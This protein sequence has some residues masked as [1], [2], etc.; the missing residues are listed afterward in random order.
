MNP[1]AERASSAFNQSCHAIAGVNSVS[2]S[3]RDCFNALI[4]IFS[5]RSAFSVLRSLRSV[6]T[7]WILRTP[8]SMAF[9]KSHSKRSVLLVG[10]MTSVRG[11]FGA[12]WVSTNSVE[13]TQRRLSASVRTPS[14]RW[15]WPST[16]PMRSPSAARNTRTKCLDSSGSKVW[17]AST[18]GA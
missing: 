3:C 15:P 4:K 8:Y 5:Q 17:M 6:Q 13:T 10:A 18:L 1:A 14:Y 12:G 7:G 11:H 9:S 2:H 16:R